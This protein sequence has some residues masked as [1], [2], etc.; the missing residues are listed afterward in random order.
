MIDIQKLKQFPLSFKAF[1]SYI[2]KQYGSVLFLYNGSGT[3]KNED[4]VCFL[5]E[6][7][8]FIDVWLFSGTDRFAIKIPNYMQW[9]PEDPLYVTRTDATEAV[10]SKAF[11]L[12]ETKLKTN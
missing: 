3:I 1:E 10:I 7:K 12:L 2:E 5:D 8:I 11:E 6:K 9:V 4:V